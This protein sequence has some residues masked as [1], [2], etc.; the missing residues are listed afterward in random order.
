M[1]PRTEFSTEQVRN[2]ARKDLLYLLEGVR[3]ALPSPRPNPA[4]LPGSFLANR[5][6]MPRFAVRRTS[7]SIAAWSAPLASSSR[8]LFFRNT[9]STSS[10]SSRTTMS[11]RA[12]ATS[13]SSR[14]ANVAAMLRR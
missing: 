5:F 8:W 3:K 9:E 2:K 11:T 1:A 7:S 13:F 14:G 10:S 6:V 4:E 12:S